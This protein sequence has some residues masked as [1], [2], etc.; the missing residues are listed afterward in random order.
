[1]N[2]S[3]RRRKVDPGEV[4]IPK[5][6]PLPEANRCPIV[7]AASLR[8]CGMNAATT[9]YFGAFRPGATAF[10][11]GIVS[12]IATL[13]SVIGFVLGLCAASRIGGL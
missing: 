1:M 12:L 11:L 3:F 4:H 5:P 9:Y 13:A 10:S 7:V 6:Q 8:A 2:D